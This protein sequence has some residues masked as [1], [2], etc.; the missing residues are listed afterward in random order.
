[1]VYRSDN[2]EFEFAVRRCLEDPR[3]DLDAFDTG[4]IEGSECGDYTSLFAS[5]RGSVDEKVWEVGTLC[6]DGESL[7]GGFGDIRLDHKPDYEDARTVPRDMLGSL[8][9]EADICRPEAPCWHLIFNSSMGVV[10]VVEDA[11]CSTK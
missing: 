8:T 5:A 4:A 10:M 2:I 11:G 9:F 6:L 1:M 7:G 3:I